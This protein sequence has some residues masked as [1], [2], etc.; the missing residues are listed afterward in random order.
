[1]PHMPAPACIHRTTACNLRSA[2]V[3]LNRKDGL[4]GRFFV[5]F[6]CE[7]PIIQRKRAK[8]VFDNKNAGKL[9]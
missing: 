2:A 5:H 6:L 8:E 9:L 1:M 4:F 7:L 3:I